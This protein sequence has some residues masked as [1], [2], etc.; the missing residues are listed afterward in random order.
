MN[1]QASVVIEKITNSSR[2]YL[3]LAYLQYTADTGDELDLD[4]SI[5][6]CTWR[7]D[8]TIIPPTVQWKFS[9][10]LAFPAKAALPP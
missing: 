2:K 1:C 4:N 5:N 6:T 7:Q 3:S 8:K 10:F 9:I